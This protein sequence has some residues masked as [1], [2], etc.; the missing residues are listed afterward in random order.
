MGFIPR[1]DASYSDDPKLRMQTPLAEANGI[2]LFTNPLIKTEILSFKPWR[3]VSQ[4]AERVEH[5]SCFRA[6]FHALFPVLVKST[7]VS[8]IRTQHH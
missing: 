7:G 4:G 6:M 5:L 8:A 2:A 3:R 1:Q